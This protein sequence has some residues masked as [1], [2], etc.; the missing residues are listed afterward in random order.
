MAARRQRPGVDEKREREAAELRRLRSAFEAK[1][2]AT[3]TRAGVLALIAA[4]PKPDAPGR[5]FHSNLAF[6][7]QQW[8]V[9]AGA[10]ADELRL[11]RDL[12]R[13]LDAQGQLTF[14]K[15]GVLERIAR[16]LDEGIGTRA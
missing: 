10:D 11:Y 7:W 12:L 14:L 6:L 13:R 8:I 1:L 2:R 4:T 3:N 15:P 5:S 16:E 9:P